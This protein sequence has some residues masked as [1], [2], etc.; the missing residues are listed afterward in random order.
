MIDM[1]RGLVHIPDDF[2]K[3]PEMRQLETPHPQDRG[4]CNSKRD[5]AGNAH[6]MIKHFPQ[7]PCHTSPP[8]LLSNLKK[9]SQS[10]RNPQSNDLPVDSIQALVRKKSYGPSE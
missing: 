4:R 6:T 8:C 1:G 9:I 10:M 2:S 3:P 7:R 5:G